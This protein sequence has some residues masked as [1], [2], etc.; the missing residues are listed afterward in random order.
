[1][2]IRC[3]LKGIRAFWNKSSNSINK[4]KI[5]KNSLL[6]LQIYKSST[7]LDVK[8]VDAILIRSPKAK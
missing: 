7:N 6:V 3:W 4:L 5:N 1:M 2:F 8:I